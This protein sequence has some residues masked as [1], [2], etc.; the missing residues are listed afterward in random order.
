M[1]WPFLYS[2]TP[3]GIVR[4]GPPQAPRPDPKQRKAP[5]KRQAPLGQEA[6]W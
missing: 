1:T 2:V 5:V 6:R 3:R 4:N